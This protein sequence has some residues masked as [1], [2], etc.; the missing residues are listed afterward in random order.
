MDIRHQRLNGW[1]KLKREAVA[2]A[3]QYSEGVMGMLW[4]VLRCPALRAR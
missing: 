4:R 2:G 1:E 3:F